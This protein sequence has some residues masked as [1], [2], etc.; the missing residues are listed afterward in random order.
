MISAFPH[1]SSR[2]SLEDFARL[3]LPGEILGKLPAHRGES[4]RLRAR[5]PR[6]DRTRFF[7]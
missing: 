1:L 5:S 6:A 2:S 4:L 7:A 3:D